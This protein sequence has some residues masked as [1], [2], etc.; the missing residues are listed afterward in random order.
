MVEGQDPKPNGQAALPHGELRALADIML[1]RVRW[2]KQIGLAFGGKRD[3]WDVLGYER[4]LTALQLREEYNRGG[5]AKRIVEA[6][7][8]ATWR[9]GVEI[10]EDPDP[11]KVT[12]FEKAFNELA[13]RLNIWSV[14]ERADILAGQ[15][16]YS[17]ILLGVAE[18]GLDTPLPQG[19]PG[20]LLYLQ[21]YWGG[22]GPS[23]TQGSRTVV[24]EVD[25]TIDSY[26]LDPRSAR[27]GDP[28]FYSLKRTNIQLPTEARKVHWSRIVH[29]AEGCLDDNVF[30]IPTLENVFNLLQ[31]LLKVTGGGAEAFWLRANQGLHAD[32]DKDM[33]LNNVDGT[34]TKIAE[35]MER[36]QH[37][38]TRWIRTR[39]VDVNTLGS[40]VANFGPSADAILKQIAGSKGIPLRILTG[41]EQGQLA[42]GQDAENWNSQVQDRRTSYAGPMIVRRLVDRLIEYGYLPRPAKYEVGWPVEE[43]MTEPQKAD[44]AVKMAQANS[45]NGD[46]LF[47]EP[48]IRE[49]TF[50]MKPLTDAQKKEI[51]D[52]AAEKFEQQQ[53]LIKARRPEAEDNVV[54][55]E[56]RAA[57]EDEEIVRVLAAAIEAGADEVIAAIVGGDA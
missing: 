10:F 25:A 38:L 23:T 16:T 15:S 2:A 14:L 20:K 11:D 9:G 53:A 54:P 31:D 26:D 35:D 6:Y 52:K 57:A 44:L 29:V 24:G 51:A 13:G 36:Y 46:V 4:T 55:F 30:G 28:L 34:L 45:T 22:G 18:G 48:E 39:G 19:E 33:A 21:P 50:D 12:E 32:I 27:F 1:D 41:S 17:V 3:Y 49:K 37:G 42:S 56:N 43:E 7:P 47:T 40:D 5:I 8:K